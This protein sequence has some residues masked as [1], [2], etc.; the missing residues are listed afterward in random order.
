MFSNH[1]QYVKE[2]SSKDEEVN[3]EIQKLIA[4]TDQSILLEG[5]VSMY[6]YKGSISFLDNESDSISKHIYLFGDVHVQNKSCLVYAPTIRIDEFIKQILI[7]LPSNEILD[8]YLESNYISKDVTTRGASNER[9]N[10][11][12][13]QLH[14]TFHSC[15]LPDK[16]SCEYKNLRLHY[17]DIR[18]PILRDPD[19]EDEETESMLNNPVY[20]LHGFFKELKMN[21]D[22]SLIDKHNT[23]FWLNYITFDE[24]FV[25][26]YRDAT[27][28][29][30]QY[31]NI[32]NKNLVTHLKNWFKERTSGY[33]EN[34]K[35][36]NPTKEKLSEIIDDLIG[37]Y[38]T[39]SSQDNL[40]GYYKN[41]DEYLMPPLESIM[42]LQ[43]LM[44]SIIAF[45]T[46]FMDEYTITRMFRQFKNIN[47]SYSEPKNIVVYVGDLHAFN[48]HQILKDLGFNLVEKKLSN[49]IEGDNF[50]CLNITGL[51]IFGLDVLNGWKD[52][53]YEVEM[54]KLRMK[55]KG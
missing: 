3:D 50:Q 37:Y 8:F 6:E 53:E 15:L 5:P 38:S 19:D 26:R 43:H 17:V 48:L 45:E 35:R 47:G 49:D 1:K 14:Y 27:K 11:Y 31:Q 9:F 24:N 21:M 2:R 39:I 51:K 12:L 29:D 42:Y 7:S 10:N 46:E 52:N 30:K 18:Q 25:Q 44:G 28:I 23:L 32:K 55:N 54:N 20:I 36:L 34:I 33:Y 22:L 16:K 4:K 40:S 13:Q 41:R